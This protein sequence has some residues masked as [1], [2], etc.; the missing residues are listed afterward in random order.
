M[1]KATIIAGL[2]ALAFLPA[3][4]KIETE[5]NAP[6]ITVTA[7]FDNEVVTLN[8]TLIMKVDYADD[9][10]LTDY[11]VNIHNIITDANVFSY[12]HPIGESTAT[13]DTFK[14]MPDTGHYE[15]LLYV[16]DNHD[17]F[18]NKVINFTVVP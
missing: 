4:D 11:T 17:N 12:S 2:V 10:I 7:P 6:T 5:Q 14:I 15:L 3:C 13:L 9:A 18:T 8:D 1:V 16:A